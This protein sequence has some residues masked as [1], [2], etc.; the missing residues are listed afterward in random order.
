MIA[1]SRANP[2]A[3]DD[4]GSPGDAGGTDRGMVTVEAAISLCGFVTVLAMVFAG[5]SMV[6]AEIRCV[7]AAREAARLVARG[8]AARASDAVGQIAPG[9]GLAVDTS[10]DEIRVSVR[11]LATSG[12]LPGVH[13]AADAFAVQEPDAA[14]S[15]PD[16]TG[17]PVVPGTAVDTAP[18]RSSRPA[19]DDRR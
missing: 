17:P 11:D 1:T 7:D 15:E 2:T 3:P 14:D 4:A 18:G 8:D 16:P 5:M 12:L 6:L 13:V 10:G 19:G 9:A